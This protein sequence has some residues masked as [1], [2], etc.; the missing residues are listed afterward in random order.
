MAPRLPCAAPAVRR[1]YRPVSRALRAARPSRSPAV[2]RA[3]LR[4]WDQLGERRLG[5]A[6]VAPKSTFVRG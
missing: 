5:R 2:R 1:A 4:G 6:V 3:R